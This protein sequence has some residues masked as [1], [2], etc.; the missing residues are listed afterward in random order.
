MSLLFKYPV[1]IMKEIMSSLFNLLQSGVTYLNPLET[2]ENLM[3]SAGI[4]K[5]NDA[6]IG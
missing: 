3:F 5:Q 2:S 4:D 6:V 1:A